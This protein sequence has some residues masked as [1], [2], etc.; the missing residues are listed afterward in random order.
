MDGTT[1][2]MLKRQILQKAIPAA[3]YHPNIPAP[4]EWIVNN[5]GM[6]GTRSTGD[7]PWFESDAKLRV[8]IGGNRAGKTTKLVLETISFCLG[9]RPWYSPDNIWHKRGLINPPV[10]CR[11]VVPN[12]ATHL[13]EVVKQFRL[14]SPRDWWKVTQKAQDGTPRQFTFFNGSTVNFMSHHMKRED[15]EG[16]ESDWNVWDEPPPQNVWAGLQRGLVSR[17]GRSGLGA[18]LLDSSGWFWDSIVSLG[19]GADQDDSILVTWHSIWDNTAENGGCKTQLVENVR[20]WL[21]KEIVDPDERLAREHGYPMHVGGL[22]L[23]DFSLAVN[24][25]DPFDLP[26]DAI[27]VS[28]I[29]PAGSRPYAGLHIAYLTLPD[30]TWEGHCFDETHLPQQKNDLGVFCKIFMEKE[31]NQRLP[32][33][34]DES[35]IILIDPSANEPQKADSLGRT[36]REI[37]EE[38]YGV[39]TMNAEKKNKRAR[40]L[41][42]NTRVKSGQYKVWKT[43]RRLLTEVRRWSWDPDSAKLTKG[44]DDVCDCWSYIDHADPPST[45]MNFSD[46]NMSKSGIYVPQRYMEKMDKQQLLKLGFTPE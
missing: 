27:I 37:I 32:A 26:S 2:E 15:F 16:I 46:S 39:C 44:A 13:T 45:L 8:S 24:V 42:L 29:D 28:C 41:R 10:S 33:H 4:E 35:V 9:F 14:W 1:P 12:F 21:T 3:F 7:R 38:D 43:C 31:R 36:M 20:H 34:P 30:G 17:S 23:K 5:G 6:P 25:I 22:V 40:L 19:D 11:Y 18:T